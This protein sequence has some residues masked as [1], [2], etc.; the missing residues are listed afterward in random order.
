MGLGM[1]SNGFGARSSKGAGAAGEAAG[2]WSA[3]GGEYSA[4]VVKRTPG[5]GLSEAALRQHE[6]REQQHFEQE[7]Q[8]QRLSQPGSV[9]AAQ[10]SM[11]R[12]TCEP[13]PEHES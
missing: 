3:S 6:Q 13:I 9:G 7:Q 1:G 10:S 4:E 5:S 11:A 12:L 2:A 8:E